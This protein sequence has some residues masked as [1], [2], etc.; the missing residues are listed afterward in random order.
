M[1]KCFK[2]PALS[3]VLLFTYVTAGLRGNKIDEIAIWSN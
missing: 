2:Y 3:K 1:V